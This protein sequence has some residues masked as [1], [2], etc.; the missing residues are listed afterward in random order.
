MPFAFVKRGE[1]NARY[2]TGGLAAARKVTLAKQNTSAKS[3]SDRVQPPERSDPPHRARRKQQEAELTVDWGARG[4]PAPREPPSPPPA[5]GTSATSSDLDDFQAIEDALRSPPR[6]NGSSAVPPP[7]PPDDSDWTHAPAVRVPTAVSPVE[8]GEDEDEDEASWAQEGLAQETSAGGLG[9]TRR[10]AGPVSTAPAV[11]GR[12][13][14]P[15][16]EHEYDDD[17]SLE[18]DAQAVGT[19][20]A[21][22]DA[23]VR[24]G[25]AVRSSPPTQWGVGELARA[26]EAPDS[27]H[28]Y[29]A[30]VE[31]A[32]LRDG[33]G[34]AFLPET[35]ARVADGLSGAE[36]AG[37]PSDSMEPEYGFSAMPGDQLPSPTRRPAPRGPH[38]TA[39]P[40]APPASWASAGATVRVGGVGSRGQSAEEDDEPPPPSA[41]IASLFKPRRS[42]ASLGEASRS[43][44]FM[45]Q[46]TLGEFGPAD[47][48]PADP[49]SGSVGQKNRP[50]GGGRTAPGRDGL[51]PGE[52]QNGRGRGR[53]AGGGAAAAGGEAAA[54]PAAAPSAAEVEALKARVGQLQ[55]ALRAAQQQA[56]AETRTTSAT[57]ASE[58]EQLAEELAQFD[59]YRARES[60]ALARDRRVLERQAKALL[61]VPDRKERSEVD[62]LKRE[63]EAARADGRAREVK[64]K[65]AASRLQKQ[66]AS[67]GRRACSPL[68]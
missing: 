4:P 38:V 57:L 55:V 53:T 34:R 36:G 21:A 20:S 68:P 31:E 14:Q 46:G 10:A 23:R 47:G 19:R 42:G 66:V 64:W 48:D 26:G 25:V 6:M 27:L 15:Y 29:N 51:H 7:P 60:A 41:L 8:E 39:A 37:D 13:S 22:A 45:P 61:K 65:M 40:L 16:W 49:A 1:G 24:A 67:G 58:R 12:G 63:L 17:G 52:R 62:A 33:D 30:E 3:G 5:R 2:E 11:A 56:A 18:Y 9:S 44:A 32:A 50:Q 35:E 54:A 59:A 43:G 28:E